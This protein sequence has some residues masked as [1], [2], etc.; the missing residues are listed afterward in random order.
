MCCKGSYS[1]P[2]AVLLAYVI[3]GLE[4]TLTLS[5]YGTELYV[6]TESQILQHL[7]V[8]LE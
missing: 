2:G 8:T 3:Y 7:T 6:K 5:E 4:V 1:Y